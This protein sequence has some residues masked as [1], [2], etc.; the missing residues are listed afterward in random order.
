[1]GEPLQQQ[2]A[3]VE[4]NL[5]QSHYIRFPEL[6]VKKKLK[7]K[8]S[9]ILS[10]IMQTFTGNHSEGPHWRGY[11][12]PAGIERVQGFSFSKDFQSVY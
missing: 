3:I 7:I 2:L 11:W 5:I 1:M 8:H 9:T 6:Q 10:Y 4:A 12:L